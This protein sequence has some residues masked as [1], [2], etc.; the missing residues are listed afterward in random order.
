[1]GLGVSLWLLRLRL[2]LS[3]VAANLALARAISL[4][5]CCGFVVANFSQFVDIAVSTALLE[6][7]YVRSG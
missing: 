4:F 3:F 5:G 6:F 2:M 1:M 7:T